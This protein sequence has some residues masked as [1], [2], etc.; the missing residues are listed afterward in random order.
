MNNLKV[1]CYQDDEVNPFV[2]LGA[3]RLEKCEAARRCIQCSECGFPRESGHAPDC[4]LVFVPVME[5]E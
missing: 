1:E 4:R 3:N 5:G 2:D